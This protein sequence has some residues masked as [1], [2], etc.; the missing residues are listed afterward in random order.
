[1]SDGGAIWGFEASNT[2]PR[3]MM[4]FRRNGNAIYIDINIGGTIRTL[5][6]GTAT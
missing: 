5:L 1:L 4:T 3:E 2:I 6:L